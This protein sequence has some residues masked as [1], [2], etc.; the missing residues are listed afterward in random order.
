MADKGVITNAEM[1]KTLKNLGMKPEDFLKIKSS[2]L[3]GGMTFKE[4]IKGV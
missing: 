1:R 4:M 2:G 3:K